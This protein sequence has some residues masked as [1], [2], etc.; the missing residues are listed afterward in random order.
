MNSN[1]KEKNKEDSDMEDLQNT[2]VE[3]KKDVKLPFD[4]RNFWKNLNEFFFRKIDSTDV[5]EV[6]HLVHQYGKYGNFII[7]YHNSYRYK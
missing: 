7:K 1:V 4:M 6:N 2:K 5:N 3:G